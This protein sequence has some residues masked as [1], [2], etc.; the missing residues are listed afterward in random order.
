MPKDDTIRQD[1]LLGETLTVS[2]RANHKIFE[3]LIESLHQTAGYLSENAAALFVAIYEWELSGIR[4]HVPDNF[5][6]HSELHR[7]YRE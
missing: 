2:E 3:P 7:R 1:T 5:V 4:H 6:R